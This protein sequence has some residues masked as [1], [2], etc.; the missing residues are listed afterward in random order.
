MFLVSSYKWVYIVLIIIIVCILAI[1]IADAIIFNKNFK[2]TEKPSLF[3]DKMSINTFI[4]LVLLIMSVFMIFNGTNQNNK[5]E[6]LSDNISL[7]QVRIRNLET[8]LYELEE[9]QKNAYDITLTFGEIS[10]NKVNIEIDFSLKRYYKN[11]IITIKAVNTED[12]NDVIEA[13]VVGVG[14]YHSN[15]TLPINNHY[16]ILAIEETLD[17]V[18]THDLKEINIQLVFNALNN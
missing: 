17:L 1:A 16:T 9:N 2:I 12:E 3:K 14:T 15:I 11:S 10:D 13:L 5:I 6:S 8:K 4:V 18:I 7:Q